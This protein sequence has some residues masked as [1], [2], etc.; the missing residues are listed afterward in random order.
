VKQGRK[1]KQPNWTHVVYEGGSREGI[2]S[3]A[4]TEFCSL[5]SLPLLLIFPLSAK[6]CIPNCD[7]TLIDRVIIGG[8]P[9]LVLFIVDS[10]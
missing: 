9:Y 1:A 6:T 4:V 3:Q 2:V 7:R 10:L 5:F 8:E